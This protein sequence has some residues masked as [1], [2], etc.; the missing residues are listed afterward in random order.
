[1]STPRSDTSTLPLAH[2]ANGTHERNS[3]NAPTSRSRMSALVMVRLLV[4]VLG[5]VI[6]AVVTGEFLVHEVGYAYKDGNDHWVNC[7]R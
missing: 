1:M 6:G 5:L 3:E 7:L 2:R 4:M